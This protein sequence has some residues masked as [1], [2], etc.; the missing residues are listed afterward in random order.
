MGDKNKRCNFTKRRP[1]LDVYITESGLSS[2]H[3]KNNVAFAFDFTKLISA[4]Q[5]KRKL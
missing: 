4:Y 3:T 5:I 2:H 1:E